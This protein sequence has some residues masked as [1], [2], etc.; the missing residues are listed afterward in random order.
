MSD[1]PSAIDMDENAAPI[2][3]ETEAEGDAETVTAKPTLKESPN[4]VPRTTT[5]W[6]KYYD[7]MG[8]ERQK[9]IARL[10]KQY[11]FNIILQPVYDEVDRNKLLVPDE[12]RV[13]TRRKISTK[14][15]WEIERRRAVIQGV[16][17]TTRDPLQVRDLLID[18][19]KGMAYIYLEN[20]ETGKVITDDEFY[21]ISWPVTKTI[22]DACNLASVTAQVPL[23][24]KI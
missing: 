22:L 24:E 11:E 17:K 4:P 14:D 15:Y 2:E 12:K 19:Y 5:A 9:V 21:R 7:E 18:M 10:A 13:F 1:Q 3:T 20:K 8:V 16:S 6:Q 23:D